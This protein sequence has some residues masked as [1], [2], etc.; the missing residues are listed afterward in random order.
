M[1]TVRDAGEETTGDVAWSAPMRVV[2]TMLDFSAS[3]ARTG[4]FGDSIPIRPRSASIPA[5]EYGAIMAQQECSVIVVDDNAAFLSLAARLVADMPNAKVV[6]RARS[7]KEALIAVERHKPDVVL[8]DLI[9]PGLDGVETT[10]LLRA[11]PDP[12][13][14]ILMT[15]EEPS[16]YREAAAKAGAHLLIDKSDLFEKLEEAIRAAALGRDEN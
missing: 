11:L 10:R 15:A 16:L 1:P 3:P 2:A 12:P 13:A 7:G 9:M 4:H 8:M 6:A 14:V 5:G